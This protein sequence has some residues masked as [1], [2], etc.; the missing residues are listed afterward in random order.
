MKTEQKYRQVAASTKAW[1]DRK[2]ADDPDAW[3][4]SRREIQRRYRAKHAVANR[5]Q[6]ILNYALETKSI[7]RPSSCQQCGKDCTPEGSHDNYNKPLEV[8]W[9]CRQCHAKK[10]RRTT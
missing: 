10:D 2:K 3:R 9:L 7:E 8:E 4:A 1:A 6:R 5:A